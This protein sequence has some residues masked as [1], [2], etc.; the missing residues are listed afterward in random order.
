[1]EELWI[2]LKF[3]EIIRPQANGW[4]ANRYDGGDGDKI[5]AELGVRFESRHFVS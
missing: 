1:M 4:L 3:Q 2:W 5:K